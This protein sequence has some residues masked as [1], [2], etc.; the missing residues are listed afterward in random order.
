MSLTV[1]MLMNKVEESQYLLLQYA[2]ILKNQKAKIGKNSMNFSKL[3]DL[4]EQEV[5]RK[6]FLRYIGIMLLGLIGVTS[7]LNNL[8]TASNTSLQQAKPKTGYGASAYG[9]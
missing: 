6:E 2:Y 5:S 3:G 4:L 8:H 1:A 7:M 9:R